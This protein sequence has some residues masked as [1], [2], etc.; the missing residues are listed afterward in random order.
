MMSDA[1]RAGGYVGVSVA[2]FPSTER[3][4]R[5][6]RD[7][8]EIDGGRRAAGVATVFLLFNTSQR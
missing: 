4:G 3:A 6:V 2:I 8:I 5:S 7:V 1:T